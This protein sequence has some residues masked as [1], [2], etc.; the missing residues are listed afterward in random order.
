MALC[1]HWPQWCR[2]HCV[3]SR[4]SWFLVPRVSSNCRSVKELS[5]NLHWSK[6]IR[7]IRRETRW[8]H[9]RG[10]IWATSCHFWNNWDQSFQLGNARSWDCLRRIHYCQSPLECHPIWAR[11]A[12]SL[13]LHPSSR[14]S[15]RRICRCP[16]YWH[17]ERPSEVRAM[18]LWLGCCNRATG[19]RTHQGDPRILFSRY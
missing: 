5:L 19:R 12:A 11:R 13:S 3:S 1:G 10:G 4:Y 2:G 17:Y 16:L 9:P 14:P 6:E 7:P 15:G 8:F 18:A